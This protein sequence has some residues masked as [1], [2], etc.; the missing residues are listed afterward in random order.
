MRTVWRYALEFNPPITKIEVPVGAK[1]LFVGLQ[2]GVPQLWM[3]INL[4]NDMET[5]RETRTF[6]FIGTGHNAPMNGKYLGTVL[7]YS[8]TL[9]LHLYE[10]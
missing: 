4:A 8:D 3:E 1:P 2:N 10:I 9:V 6:E 7:M 5:E